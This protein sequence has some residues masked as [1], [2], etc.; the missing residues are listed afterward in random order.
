MA[1]FVIFLGIFL[2]GALLV[3]FFGGSK[4]KWESDTT[5]SYNGRSY[6]QARTS[7][8]NRYG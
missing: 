3:A 6:S 2:V 8:Y 1:T 4:S 7:K 5:T